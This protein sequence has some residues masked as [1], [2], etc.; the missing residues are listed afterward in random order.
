MELEKKLAE[1]VSDTQLDSLPGGTFV[2]L[3]VSGELVDGTPFYLTD[4]VRLV[5]L[6]PGPGGPPAHQEPISSTFETLP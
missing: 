2:E 4:C 6:G 5:P 3:A 1:Y